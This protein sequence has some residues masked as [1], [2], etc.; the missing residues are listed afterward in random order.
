MSAAIK[1]SGLSKLY[2]LGVREDNDSARQGGVLELLKKPIEN[3]KKHKALAEFGDVDFSSAVQRDDILWAL[4]DVSFEIQQ[5]EI[6][7][8]I[9][10]NGAGKS[11]LLK[12]LSRITPPARGRVEIHGRV[13]SLLEVG[14]GFHME[15]TGRENVYLNGTILGMKKREIDRQ[16]DEI[17]AFSGIE[18]FIDTP[19]KRYSSGM[20]VR[21]AFAVA[22][23]LNPEILIVDEVLAVGDRAFQQKCLNKMQDVGQLGAT[24][25]FV[26]HSMPSVTRLCSRGILMQ[27]GRVIKDGSVGEV[28]SG[29][30]SLCLGTASQREWT[31]EATAPQSAAVR[32]R[33]VRVVNVDGC[34]LEAAEIHR[35]IGLQ[36]EFDVLIDGGVLVP[37]LDLY[38]EEGLHLFSTT[39]S[40]ATSLQPRKLGRYRI[41]AWIPGNLLTDG[42]FYVDLKVFTPSPFVEHFSVA[43]AAAFQVIDQSEGHGARGSWTGEL[44]GAVRPL[45]KWTNVF[46]DAES[47]PCAGIDGGL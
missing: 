11:T 10:T 36:T 28:V 25:L 5:G 4:R 42:T 3:Y 39:D 38:D 35:P 47:I 9:G 13:Y 45:L 22:A 46:R 19:A 14:T 18:K 27:A 8:I 2:R 34:V 26:S 37:E 7:G 33:A 6:V 23:H 32:L 29:Y 15:L 20:K 40:D 16:F 30:L 31:E 41:T 24:V 44:G 43:Q 12:I 1:V 21:L 17:V